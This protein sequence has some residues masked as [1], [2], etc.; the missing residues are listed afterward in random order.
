LWRKVFRDLKYEINE[1]GA[2][3]RERITEVTASDVHTSDITQDDV[4]RELAR[5]PT[6]L[7]P[8]IIFDEFD[9]VIDPKTKAMMSHTIKAISESGT[10]ATVILVGIA[11]DVETLIAEHQ[12]VERNIAEIKMPRMSKDE[13][14]E[15]LDKRLLP[16]GIRIEGDARWKIISLARGLP[17]YVHY[18]GREAA[19]MAVR[20]RRL[21]IKEEDVDEAIALFIKDSDRTSYARYRKAI[22]SNKT[23]AHYKHVLLA[24]ALTKT[25]DEDATFAPKDVIQPATMIIGHK[26]DI[27]N[28]Q[29]H[30]N[31]FISEA[32][33]KIF[34]RCGT[35]RAYRYKFSEPKMQP[36]VIMQGIS[37]RM[38]SRDALAVLAAP[39]QPRLSNDF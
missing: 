37:D 38:V 18:L 35:E 34:E 8:V 2:Y 28:F 25:S 3:G 19:I 10:G 20:K 12:S 14:N 29:S 5:K 24:C 31:A 33:G 4:I 26:V 6:K 1:N 30:L 21:L 13:M 39:E 27:A 22:E 23:N 17:E 15:I 9:L 16:L 7:S 36:Y 11:G 32:R